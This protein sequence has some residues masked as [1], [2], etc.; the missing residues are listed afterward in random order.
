MVPKSR[1]FEYVILIVL[2]KEKVLNMFYCDFFTTSLDFN[3][4]Q[5]IL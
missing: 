5:K 2:E 1:G 4:G 3:G